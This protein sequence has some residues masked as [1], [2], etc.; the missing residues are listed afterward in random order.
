VWHCQR[1]EIATLS[2]AACH[3]VRSKVEFGMKLGTETTTSGESEP[4]DRNGNQHCSRDANHCSESTVSLTSVLL[5]DR[6]DFD[7]T[8]RAPGKVLV[9][10]IVYR[11]LA[12]GERDEN[13]SWGAADAIGIGI[14]ATEEFV[15]FIFRPQWACVL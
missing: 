13:L 9:S 4:A 15:D 8:R 7:V 14:C 2:N 11:A 1:T 5:L 12:P 10:R 6:S 3:G